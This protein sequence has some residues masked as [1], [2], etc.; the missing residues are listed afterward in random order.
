LKPAP[1]AYHSKNISIALVGAVVND[2]AEI[3][4]WENWLEDL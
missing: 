3:I 4:R 1:P 2:L